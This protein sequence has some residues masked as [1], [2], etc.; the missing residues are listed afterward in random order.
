LKKSS[1]RDLGTIGENIAIKALKDRGLKI[2]WQNFRCRYGEIDII[3]KDNQ[4][5]VFVEVK[6]RKSGS[7]GNPEEAVNSAKKKKLRFLANHYLALNYSVVQPCRFDVFSII[8]DS[9][10]Q[11]ISMEVFKNCF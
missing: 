11:P 7:Y 1:R 10:N 3:A 2:L 5:I 9:Y 6:T 4:E 8:L